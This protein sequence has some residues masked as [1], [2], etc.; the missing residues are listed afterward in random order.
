[1]CDA[2]FNDLPLPS[3]KL[4]VKEDTEIPPNSAVLVPVSCASL[5]NSTVIFNPSQLFSRRKNIPLPFSVLS[6]EN[7]FSA[8]Y[9]PNPSTSAFTVLRGECIGCVEPLDTNLLAKGPD[10]PSSLPVS[11]LTPSASASSSH[12][13]FSSVDSELSAPQRDRLLCLL[14]RFRNSFDCEQTSL[15][16][17]STVSHN[18]ETGSHSPLRQRPY[19]VSAAERRIIEE[20]V[21]DMLHRGVIRPSNSPWASPVVL[22]KKKDGSIRFC[23]D[24]RRLNKITRKDVYPLP[25][26]DDALDSLQGAEFFSSLDL[27]SGYW[28]VPMADAD[29]PKTAFVTPDGLYEFNVMPF[30]LCNAPATFERMMDTIL[31]GLKWKI[32]LCY[33]DDIVVFSPDFD[34]PRAPRTS[35]EMPERCRPSTQS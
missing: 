23:V 34:T 22:V 24:Y 32:C 7:G 20:Q 29:R 12:V 3:H 35:I 21:D 14:N 30:G 4:A 6:L 9:I 1:M 10:D 2:Q 5:I 8:M 33:L 18:I 15:G 27:R 28:Q 16:G 31:R 26:I 11:A 13:L 25:R 17:S 19:R